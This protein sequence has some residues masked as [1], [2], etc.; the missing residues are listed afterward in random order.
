MENGLGGNIRMEFVNE[1]Y[2]LPNAMASE[3]C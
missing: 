3:F 2:A 1:K